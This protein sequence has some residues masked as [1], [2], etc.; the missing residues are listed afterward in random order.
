MSYNLN[1]RYLASNIIQYIAPGAFS[2]LTALL[3][4]FASSVSLDCFNYMIDIWAT[5]RLPT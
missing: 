2:G 1:D 4:L 3:A 5:I